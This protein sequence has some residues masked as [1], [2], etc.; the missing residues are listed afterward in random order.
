MRKKTGKRILCAFCALCMLL[1]QGG[2]LPLF[3]PGPAPSV[4]FA[5]GKTA[6]EWLYSPGSMYEADAP[7]TSEEDTI[8]KY[9]SITGKRAFYLLPAGVPLPNGMCSFTFL[10]VL[11]GNTTVYAYQILYRL[12]DETGLGGLSDRGKKEKD[13]EVGK[14]S[15]TLITGPVKLATILMTYN[16]ETEEYRVLFHDLQNAEVAY[17]SGETLAMKIRTAEA[18]SSAGKLDLSQMKAVRVSD[19]VYALYYREHLYTIHAETGET[20]DLPVRED[21]QIFLKAHPKEK[22][23]TWHVADL[24]ADAEG[25]RYLLLQ[26]VDEKAL[27]NDSEESLEKGNS[28]VKQ[29]LLTLAS[30]KGELRFVSE[31]LS[32]QEQEKKFLTYDGLTVRFNKIRTY[33]PS[34]SEILSEI[35]TPSSVV[36]KIPNRFSPWQ[37]TRGNR[38]Y[39]LAYPGTA[40]KI[41][42]PDGSQYPSPGTDW[43]VEI[44]ETIGN[45]KVTAEA[46]LGPQKQAIPHNEEMGEKLDR[47]VT[48]QY[49]TWPSG[50][51]DPKKII[52]PETHSFLYSDSGSFLKQR[53]ADFPAGEF[54]WFWNVSTADH[55]GTA[56]FPGVLRVHAAGSKDRIYW[57]KPDADS[58]KLNPE[59]EEAIGMSFADSL[60]LY[61]MQFQSYDGSDKKTAVLYTVGSEN[62]SLFYNFNKDPKQSGASWADSFVIPKKKLSYSHGTDDKGNLVLSF[63]E[64]SMFLKKES[65]SPW[66]YAATLSEGLTRTSLKSQKQG[67]GGLSSTTGQ[68]RDFQCLRVTASPKKDTFLVF[69]FDSRR[70]DF[71]ES[72]L[73]YARVYQVSLSE[74]E[75]LRNLITSVL[76]QPENFSYKEKLLGISP[77]SPEYSSAWT[78][79]YNELGI[80]AKSAA[81]PAALSRI[82]KMLVSRWSY[83]MRF[84]RLTHL[85]K[86]KDPYALTRDIEAC[87][88]MEDLEQVFVTY[89]DL[90]VIDD[91]KDPKDEP[92]GKDDIV[93]AKEDMDKRTLL[94]EKIRE[95]QNPPMSQGDWEVELGLIVKGLTAG[96]KTEK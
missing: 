48:V 21:L 12:G 16:F 86:A 71:Q 94:L 36:S 89:T 52:V 8:E 43:R 33:P 34:T 75:S 26:C 85:Q 14:G 78:A 10:D 56:P 61:D 88:T 64:G 40:G 95:L 30:E 15:G 70:N 96:N 67:S 72:D 1:L 22:N 58:L 5:A 66:L 47:R 19:G 50:K 51:I 80:G 37:L 7:E 54:H 53:T 69:G 84:V 17:R 81:D 63:T 83:V 44:E 41:V 76:D 24:S 45:R 31:N 49:K 11:S 38:K 42:I 39:Q 79:F 28:S 60:L 91:P 9:Q 29:Y 87:Q 46:Y 27:D 35:G 23:L 68:L 92:D 77:S 57:E 73:P 32:R 25:G 59:K 65:G 3:L 82:Q 2:L 20:E 4:S 62:V 13:E 93:I 74:E 6:E 18:T 90:K 55:I